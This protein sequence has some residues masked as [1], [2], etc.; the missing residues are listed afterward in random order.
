MDIEGLVEI[1]YIID[2]EALEAID[3][4]TLLDGI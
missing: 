2:L 1:T 3:L 4:N